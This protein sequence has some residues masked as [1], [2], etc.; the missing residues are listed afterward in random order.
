M[1]FNG[2]RTQTKH[3]LTYFVPSS[4]LCCSFRLVDRPIGA[5]LVTAELHTIRI[6]TACLVLPQQLRL[7]VRKR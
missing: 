3:L 2:I 4:L 7:C 1:R 6:R 5:F